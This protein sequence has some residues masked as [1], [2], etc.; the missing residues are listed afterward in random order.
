MRRN[1]VQGL[2]PKQPSG[3][4]KTV[5][6][7]KTDG[8]LV[9]NCWE[10]KILTGRYCM[11]M[12]TYEYECYSVGQ[13]KWSKKKFQSLFGDESPYYYSSLSEQ[14]VMISTEDK[15]TVFKALKGDEAAWI[16]GC[17]EI[18]GFREYR[19][20]EEIK[21]RTEQ[22]RKKKIRDMMEKVPAMPDDFKEWIWGLAAAGK[23]YIFYGKE[24]KEWKCTA[25]GG[26][27]DE[28]DLKRTDGGKKARNN[29]MVICPECK[30]T[31]QAK[32][33]TSAMNLET[34]CTILQDIDKETSVARHIDVEIRWEGGKHTVRESE[35]MRIFLLRSHP[36]LRC[37]IFYSHVNKTSYQEGE[38]GRQ[39]P[40]NRRAFSS[41]L[42]PAGI[43]EALAGTEYEAWTRVFVQFSSARQN[44]PYNRMLAACHPESIINISEYLFKGRF[45]R[46]LKETMENISYWSGKYHGPLQ[47]EGESLEAVFGIG[48]RQKINRIRDCNGGEEVLLWMQW[49]E[50]TGE[51]ISEQA[52][53]WLISQKITKENT[54]FINQRMTLQ[55]IMNYVIKQQNGGYKGKS[56]K[57]VLGQW[58]DYLSMCRGENK[59]MEDELVYRPR[60]LKRRHDEIVEEIRKR[61]MIERMEQSKEQNKKEAEEMRKKYPGAEEIMDKVRKKYEYKNDEYMVIMPKNL[62]E[63]VTEGCALHHCAAW[64]DIYIDRIMQQETYL[65]FLRRRSEEDLPYY[66]IEIEPGGTIRQHRSFYDEEPGIEEIRKFLREWQG[67]VKKRL[68]AKD[69]NLAEISAVKRRK[70]IEKLKEK[71]N[72]RVLNGLMEDFMEV[73]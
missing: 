70:N 6:V 40:C 35:A 66:T 28:K 36:K 56:A 31:V 39:N 73:I 19:Y 42:Y 4:G 55:Q 20:A 57:E 67:A 15:D 11:N 62:V 3:S 1:A 18:I 44:L 26:T 22:N 24:N 64:S 58:A 38:F 23:D 30:K 33:R 52:L 37:D 60:E 10:D 5:T 12:E 9:I 16:S 59:K 32:K 46:L 49:S 14:E 50:E 43:K 54:S 47:E 27:C 53:Y 29:D 25:C 69:H 21:N 17:Y 2:E 48:D 45:F 13:K 72:T 51:K 71:N 7:Q 65:C 41:Y 68:S 61:K 8:I 63:I 34:R